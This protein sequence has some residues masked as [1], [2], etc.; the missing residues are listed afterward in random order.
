MSVRRQQ[1]PGARGTPSAS[2]PTA[3]TAA[4]AVHRPLR[5]VLAAG[6]GRASAVT[7]KHIGGNT[8]ML[9]FMVPNELF[10]PVDI[11]FDGA[12]A[13]NEFDDTDLWKELKDKAIFPLSKWWQEH[14]KNIGKLT[15]KDAYLMVKTGERG[16]NS[17]KLKF[18]SKDYWSPQGCWIDGNAGSATGNMER[19]FESGP[20]FDFKAFGKFIFEHKDA[21]DLTIEY[22]DSGTSAEWDTAP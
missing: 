4:T 10:M 13:E 1:H 6:R 7:G 14:G 20:R 19:A 8:Y 11:F 9:T 18:P 21:P 12:E 16:P 17:R 2:K 15:G 22:F 3:A 5:A